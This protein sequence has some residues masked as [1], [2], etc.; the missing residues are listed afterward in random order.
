MISHLQTLP[1]TNWRTYFYRTKHGAEIDFILDGHF[2]LLPIE[3]KFGQTVTPKQLI[4]LKG[5]IE[6][7]QLPLGIIINQADTI[8]MLTENIIQIPV[9]YIV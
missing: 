9:Q 3:I 7:H 4:T 2:G 6:E 1:I 8:E 5:F